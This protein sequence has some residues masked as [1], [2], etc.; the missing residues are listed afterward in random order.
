MEERAG[1]TRPARNYCVGSS[2]GRAHWTTT[3]AGPAGIFLGMTVLDLDLLQIE[4]IAGEW[5]VDADGSRVEM[6]VRVCAMV[7]LRGRFTGVRGHVELGAGPAGCRLHVDVDTGSLTTGSAR[8]DAVLAAAGIIDPAAGPVLTYRSH[9]IATDPRGGWRIDGVL[10]T[11]RCALPLRLVAAAPERL[12]DGLR[13]RAR[14][15]VTREQILRLLAAPGA[16]VLLGSHA[17]LDL[18]LVV[19]PVR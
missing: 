7:G 18:T 6:A 9:V 5:A 14:G 3:G 19:R 1:T 8:R 15:R 10:G 17:Q 13:M 11:S 2:P 16:G 12:P 4:R